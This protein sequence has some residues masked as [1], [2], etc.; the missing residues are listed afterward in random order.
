ME[1]FQ[2]KEI[3]LYATVMVGTCYHISK[4]CTSKVNPNVTYGCWIVVMMCPCRF[5]DCNKCITLEW[6]VDS[7]AGCVCIQ[8]GDT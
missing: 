1:D 6:D 3:I 5:L 7:G 8:A 2:G 4:E